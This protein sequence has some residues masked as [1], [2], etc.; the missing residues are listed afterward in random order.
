LK[1]ILKPLYLLIALLSGMAM[2]VQGSL[3]SALGKI[4][5]LVNATLIVHV[6][7]TITVSAIVL[8]SSS[9]RQELHKL[10]Q[11]PWYTLLGGILSVIII[12][13]VARSIP[14]LGVAV[15]TTAII[16]GQVSTALAIDHLGLFGLQ[17]ICFTW[18]KLVGMI[19]LA[20]GALLMLYH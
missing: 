9:D 16:V 14:Q 19:L 1:P 10:T 12:Y 3:N 4:I 20:G 5:G 15:A 11:V 2:A 18:W 6:I 7:G 8:L 13:L 17:P